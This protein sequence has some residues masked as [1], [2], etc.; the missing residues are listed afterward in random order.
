MLCTFCGTLGA[1]A[2]LVYIHLVIS[3]FYQP[4]VILASYIIAVLDKWA[5]AGVIQH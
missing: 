2:R 4:K 3:K 5:F 1:A